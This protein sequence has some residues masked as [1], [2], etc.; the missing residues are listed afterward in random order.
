MGQSAVSQAVWALSI[1]GRG[2]ERARGLHSR[3]ERQDPG[4]GGGETRGR[5]PSLLFE[6]LAF[7]HLRARR[8]PR[9]FRDLHSK[10]CS[11]SR[12]DPNTPGCTSR[13]ASLCGCRSPNPRGPSRFIA[14]S[15][16]HQHQAGKLC[17]DKPTLIFTTSR[18]SRPDQTRGSRQ[19]CLQSDQERAARK[20]QRQ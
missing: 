1:A 17:L 9:P 20:C 19:L 6:G 15:Y 5:A 11:R 14:P 18:S 13:A 4:D 2:K 8:L 12:K 16:L 7:P 3:R 10:Q